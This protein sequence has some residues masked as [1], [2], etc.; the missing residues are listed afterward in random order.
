MGS[1]DR[2]EYSVIGDAVN[3]A[4]RITGAA[5]GGRVWIGANTLAKVKHRI[6]IKP[7]KSL[8]VKGKHEPIPVYEVLD[9]LNWHPD[10]LGNKPVDFIRRV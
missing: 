3:V 7:L 5:S 2:L 6:M 8:I 9:I 4:A 10:D 1:K